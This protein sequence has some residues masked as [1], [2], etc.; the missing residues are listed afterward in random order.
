M[1][2]LKP[3]WIKIITAMPFDVQNGCAFYLP[4]R[5]DMADVKGAAA[6]LTSFKEL[7]AKGQN[8]EAY[9]LLTQLKVKLTEFQ[10]LPPI[11][12][13]TP[14]K[15]K[16]CMIARDLLEHS[17]FLAINM[18]VCFLNDWNE[19]WGAQNV[20]YYSK[21]SLCITFTKLYRLIR[22]PCKKWLARGSLRLRCPQD[23]NSEAPCIKQL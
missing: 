15:E 2:P 4:K 17:I 14:T 7:V 1:T 12:Q 9:R 22:T 11:L 23:F 5:L 20:Q 18:E 6:Q 21:Q 16:E 10:A 3:P 13:N 19:V 8:D